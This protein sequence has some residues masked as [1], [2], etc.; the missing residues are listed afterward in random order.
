MNTNIR[1]SILAILTYVLVIG[2]AT[3]APVVAKPIPPIEVVLPTPKTQDDTDQK[4][5][6]FLVPP[7]G[8]VD[9]CL[10][11]LALF[12]A[13]EEV[14]CHVGQSKQCYEAQKEGC[15]TALGLTDSLYVSCATDLMSDP[16]CSPPVPDG[17]LS[18]PP[19]EGVHT[20]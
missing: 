20:L 15:S 5:A 10:N 16:S 18:P 8:Q 14:L 4:L 1:L 12:C 2:C 7:P 9:R 13:R 3:Q 17:C 19:P 11:L 6:E